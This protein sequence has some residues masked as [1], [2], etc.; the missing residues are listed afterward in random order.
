MRV[1]LCSR[2]HRMNFMT[3]QQVINVNSDYSRGAYCDWCRASI[4]GHHEFYHCNICNYD[5]CQECVAGGP[6]V[7]DTTIQPPIESHAYH[8][9][10]NVD[11]NDWSYPQLTPRFIGAPAPTYPPGVM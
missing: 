3:I 1:P 11:P 4:T 5:I 9:N 10:R 6:H 8:A 2:N 7:I